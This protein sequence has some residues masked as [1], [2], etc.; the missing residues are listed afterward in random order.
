[1]KRSFVVIALAAIFV[2]APAEAKLVELS[3]SP[4]PARLGDH[5]RHT[6][7]MGG[8]SRIELFLSTSGFERP[9]LGTLPPGAWAYR[10]CPPQ[11][12]G[13]PAWYYRSNVVAPP[14]SYR[15]GAVARARGT[16]LST[17]VT[18]MGPDGVWVRIT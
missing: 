18:S 2:A 16:F 1:M 11:T 15:F 8:P 4:N 10:C 5:V 7:S 14:G 6:V 17:A 9:G 12:T 3:A 13:T